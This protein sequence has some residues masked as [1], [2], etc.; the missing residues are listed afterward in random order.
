MQEIN[1]NILNYLTSFS[2]NNFISN[3][4]WLLS[5]APIFFLPIFLLWY[6]LYYNFKKDEKNNIFSSTQ[7]KEILLLILYST[8]LALVISL[9][10]QQFVNIERPEWYI[11]ESAK[12]LMEHLPDAS[13]PSDHATV[14]FAFLTSLFLA[15]YKKTWF[16]FMPFVIIMNISRIIAWVHWPFDILA[17]TIVWILSSF[18]IFKYL[19]NNKII[20]KASSII[21]KYM[22]IIKL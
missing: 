2:N 21:I 19:K 12:L 17:W 5:D 11:N 9:I 20:T 16:Y 18:I 14:S 22:K 7:N 13:F 15:W 4:I 3:N 6:W 10:I 8:V 1:I